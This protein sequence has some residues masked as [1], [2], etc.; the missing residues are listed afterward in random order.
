[1][2][3]DTDHFTLSRRLPLPPDR[4][5]QVLTD[6]RAR[7]QWGAPTEG[8]VLTVEVTD[9]REGGHERHRCGPAD[10]PDFVVDTRWYHLDPPRRAVF[11]ETV[12]IGDMALAT[13]LVTYVLSTGDD[14]TT[15]DLAVSLSS[16]SGP[17]S[18]PEFRIGWEGGLA[19]LDRYVAGLASESPA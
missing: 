10:A 7:E 9:L 1:M 4:L 3:T 17:G 19:N 5:W 6:A 2:T 14:G 16:F 12:R 18:L 11:N 15:L 8:T 13:S